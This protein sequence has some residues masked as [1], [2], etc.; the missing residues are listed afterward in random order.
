MSGLKL[1][2]H[3]SI[4]GG[5]SNALD[6]AAAAQSNAVQ[7][8]M[9]SNRQ[10]SGPQVESRGCL[11]LEYAN[12]RLRR[13]LRR[14]PRLLSHQPGLAQRSPVGEKRRRLHG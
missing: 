11:P 9:K 14:Q 5:V 2:A 1:G 8:F 7:V 3:M 4:A 12:A 10:W 6:A 13:R